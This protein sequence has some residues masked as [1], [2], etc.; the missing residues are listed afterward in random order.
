MCITIRK[1]TEWEETLK[2][3]WNRLV[4]ED[5]HNIQEYFGQ[6][7]GIHNKELYGDGKAA[8]SITEQINKHFF[9][10]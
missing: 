10:D 2:E 9:Q 7:P 1:E 6:T 3:N 5:L 4:F 8:Q